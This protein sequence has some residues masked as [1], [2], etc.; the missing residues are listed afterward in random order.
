MH[1]I[2][3][4]TGIVIG[5][6]LLVVLASWLPLRSARNVDSL[7]LHTDGLIPALERTRSPDPDAD[8]DAPDGPPSG[9]PVGGTGTAGGPTPSTPAGTPSAPARSRAPAPPPRPA[10]PGADS[11]LLQ[12]VVNLVNQKRSRAGCRPVRY[13][14]RLAA[15]AQAHAA[16]M[17]A[18][19]YFSHDTPE[20]AG[21]QHRA[22]AAGYDPEGWTGENIARDYHDAETVMANWMGSRQNRD[23]ILN[24][25]ARDIGMGLARDRLGSPF[26]V[27]TFGAGD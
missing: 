19:G 13:D 21:P 24:C 17:A 14:S 3:R 25:D 22:G 23:I 15:A 5:L 27:Q 4:R 8:A 16:D 10:R 1:T 6:V 2:L 26:W 12:Q 7:D 18:R 20:G 9:A 11:A